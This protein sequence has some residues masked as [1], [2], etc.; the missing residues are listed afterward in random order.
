MKIEEIKR[1]LA[2]FT[3]FR[4]LNDFEL[5]K[6]TDIAIS[7]EWKK[8]SHVFLQGDPLENVYFIYDGKIKIYK[9]DINGKEQIVAIAK[10]GEMFPH[11]G[12]FRKGD[13]P[14]YA[15]VLESSTLI[16]IPI[17]K[18][19]TVLIDN[20]ELCIKVFKVLGEKIVD[21]Q[22]RLEEQILNNTYEQ[23]VKLLIRLAQNH[24][25]EQEDG[26]ILLKSEFT[27]KDLAN[28]I[29]T[30]RETISRTLTKMKKDELIEV[31]DEGNM[32]VDIKILMEEIHLI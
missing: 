9:S 8:Q 25:K 1:V 15:E 3:L 12:F 17:S 32:I 30:T 2:D 19:E 10:K 22:N 5:T 16:A 27:N 31:D 14:A 7:R 24:G 13:Y 26:T 4:E 20:P 21:L 28:M 18:F 23:I 11:V 29:G 6:I